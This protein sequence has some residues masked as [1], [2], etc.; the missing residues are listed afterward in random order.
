[1]IH[2]AD[3]DALERFGERLAALIGPGDMIALSGGLGAGKTTLARGVLRGL[4]YE[5]EAPS[6]SFAILQGYEPPELRLPVAHVDLYRIEEP[7]EIAELGLFDWLADGAILVEWPEHGGPQM[8]ANSL[9]FTLA[10]DPQG[11][12]CLTAAV[13]GAWEKRWLSLTQ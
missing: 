13:P 11:G 5:G 12:R 6:P 8:S 3:A 2:F 1:M 10:P 9:H 7:G 4:G